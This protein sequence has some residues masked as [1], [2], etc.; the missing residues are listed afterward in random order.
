VRGEILANTRKIL[1]R[2]RIHFCQ[3]LN[4]QETGGVVQIG[5]HT[6]QPLVPEHSVSEAEAVI[7]KFEVTSRHMLIKFQKN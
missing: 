1:N 5:M 7:G 3:L 4:V 6:A 2:W